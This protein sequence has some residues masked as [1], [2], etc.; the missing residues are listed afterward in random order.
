MNW[1]ALPDDGMS[2]WSKKREALLSDALNSSLETIAVGVSIFDQ[3]QW[4]IGSNQNFREHLK[5]PRTATRA[6]TALG[7]LLR[8]H[9]RSR[10]FIER[11]GRTDDLFAMWL[12]THSAKLRTSVPFNYNGCEMAP[13]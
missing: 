13:F 4:L 5:L 8:Y 7:E 1:R 10:T 3:S 11:C 2:R 6:G 9:A 12:V